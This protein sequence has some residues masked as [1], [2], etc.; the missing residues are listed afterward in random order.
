MSWRLLIL[1]VAWASVAD[2]AWY[3]ASWTYRQKITIDKTQ[4]PNTNQT[5][6]PVFVDLANMASGFFTHVLS[7]G[8]DIRVT[9][10]DEVTEVARQV[11]AI[12]TGGSTG[13]LWVNI[14]TVATA[15]NTD[16]YVYYGNAGATEPA[17]NATYGSQNTWNANFKGVW[18]YQETSG[19][20]LSDATAQGNT[21]T[22]LAATTPNPAT[23]KIGGGQDFES[24]TGD[25]ANRT[26]APIVVTS[27]YTVE[28][29]LN[30]E[31]LTASRTVVS[32]GCTGGGCVGP[33][34]GSP[35]WFIKINSSG[36]FLITCKNDSDV[37][38]DSTAST[39]VLSTSTWYHLVATRSGTTLAWYLNGAADLSQT[40]T[41]GSYA[42]TA[43]MA[44][45]AVDRNTTITLSFDGILD[46]LR[47]NNI[48]RS[49]D[50][51]ATEY[52]NQ[53]SSSTFYTVGAETTAAGVIGTRMRKLFGIGRRGPHWPEDY[54]PPYALGIF[55]P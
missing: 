22:K 28:T 52:N 26:S 9:T 1:L 19:T 15:T 20:T 13:E 14:P 29:W 21:L 43:R 34:G 49:A 32:E 40:H 41:M 2:A 55:L 11:V 35:T 39:T 12:S 5:N 27:A 3:D 7:D 37:G 36:K 8:G 38:E 53:S 4:V 18:H 46:E 33:S 47:M 24:G 23:G 31:S 6:F 25:Y 16:F 54:E 51:I 10:S 50:W 30:L 44:G 17:A 42:N 45:G 48:A